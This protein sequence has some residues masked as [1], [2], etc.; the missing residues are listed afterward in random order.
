[1]NRMVL[2]IVWPSNMTG[3]ELKLRLSDFQEQEK[4]LAKM[5]K[6]SAGEIKRYGHNFLVGMDHADLL[7]MLSEVRGEVKKIEKALKVMDIRRGDVGNEG[8]GAGAVPG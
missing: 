5:I 7:T 4:G 3:G 1:M 8:C 6:K 2:N